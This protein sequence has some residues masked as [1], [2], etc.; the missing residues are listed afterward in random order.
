VC[1]SDIDDWVNEVHQGDAKETLEEMPADSVHCVVTSSPYYGLRNYN[2]DGQIGLEDS[3]SQYIQ[4]L[5]DVGD[6][7][8]RV[9]R[10]DGSWWL[11]LGDTYS[12]G[13][14]VAGKP[15][16]WDD[17]HQDE[18]YPD[19]PPAKNTSFPNKDKMLVPHRTAIALQDE[20]WIV[21]NDVVW[22]KTSPMPESVTDR[23]STTF[24]FFFHFVQQGNYYYDLDSIRKPY[25]ESSI[26]RVNQNNG[27][28]N[29]EGNA[30]RGHPDGEETLNP[31]QF[32]H[33]NGKNPGDI[34]EVTTA[35]FP[36]AHFAVFPTELIEKPIKA[37]C[38]SEVCVECGRPYALVKEEKGDVVRGEEREYSPNIKG[39][40]APPQKGWQRS[41]RELVGWE[42]QCDC[43]ISE[44]EPGIV[45][46]PFIGAGTT[47]VVA[48]DLERRWIGI[49][50]NKDYVEMSEERAT[51][52]P[53]PRQH[54]GAMSW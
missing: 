45:L 2:C 5:V 12:G 41:S 37:S 1:M 32:T 30:E 48:Q 47:A 28:P 38:P 36:D 16:D 17:M 49:D 53:G 51:K 46:D 19:E 14:G 35:Q 50:L 6:E 15:D 26:Q 34:F 22:S 39:R 4:Q 29:W 23:L 10:D 21:R 7:L 40:S 9:L 8:Q 27:N 31:N 52:N 3:L 54:N 42:Q 44:T 25:A 33:S 20:G 11:N 18:N 24:E 13:G 43:S